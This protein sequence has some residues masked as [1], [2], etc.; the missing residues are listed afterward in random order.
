LAGRGLLLERAVARQ[1][2][3]S[4]YRSAQR[5]TATSSALRR[6]PALDQALGTGV[7]SLDQVAAAAEFATPASDAELARLAVA[8]R[9]AR[10]RWRRV[11]SSRRA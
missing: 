3:S 1:L 9:P 8:G 2:S 5:I 10:S 6:L 4:D 11:R 7:L